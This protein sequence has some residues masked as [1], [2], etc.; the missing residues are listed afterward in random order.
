MFLH[1]LLLYF[2]LI[3]MENGEDVQ[4]SISSSAVCF[5]SFLYLFRRS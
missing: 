2:G 4:Q 1:I 5:F 3:L